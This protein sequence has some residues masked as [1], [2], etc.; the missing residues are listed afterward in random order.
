MVV[1]LGFLNNNIL[2][3]K[4]LQLICCFFNKQNSLITIQNLLSFFKQFKRGH[5]RSFNFTKLKMLH[6]SHT[7]LLNQKSYCMVIEF[8]LNKWRDGDY[9]LCSIMMKKVLKLLRLRIS[10]QFTRS[11]SVVGTIKTYN[12]LVKPGCTLNVMLLLSALKIHYYKVYLAS[13]Y[14]L[15]NT[16]TTQEATF[17][18]TKPRKTFENLFSAIFST[19]FK[20]S[21]LCESYRI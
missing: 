21:T 3:Y 12:L 16:R 10:I 2:K 14:W 6:F 4:I 5:Q 8:I 19:I 20:L 7:F 17:N 9:L 13:R 1:V 15:I 18:H 11:L